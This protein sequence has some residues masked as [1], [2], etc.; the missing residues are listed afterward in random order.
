MDGV[1]VRAMR[2]IIGSGFV[3]ALLVAGSAVR[4]EETVRITEASPTTE[5]LSAQDQSAKKSFSDAQII[6]MLIAA[7]RAAYFSGT[8]GPCACPDDRAR[9]GSRCGARSAYSRAKGWSVLCSP[10]DVSPA[11]IKQYRGTAGN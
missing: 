1:G 7:S 10:G 5:A 3:L 6:A 8:S 9:N 2:S 11:M 4:G